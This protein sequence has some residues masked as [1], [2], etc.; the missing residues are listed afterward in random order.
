MFL[1]PDGMFGWADTFT[2]DEA[3]ARHFYCELFGWQAYDRTEDMG[4]HYTQFFLDGQL[5]AGMSPM[6]PEM[7]AEGCSRSGSPTCWST[8][9]MPPV[10]RCGPRADR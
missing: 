5:V 9:P 1:H 7:S 4:A 3:K 10:W 6:P 2:S 8:T